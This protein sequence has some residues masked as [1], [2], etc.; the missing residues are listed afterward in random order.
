MRTRPL[1]TSF[2]SLALI[3]VLAACGADSVLPS[4]TPGSAGT[5]QPAATATAAG[6]PGDVAFAQMMIP[7][8]QQAIAMADMALT[9][10]STPQVGELAA[11]IKAAQDP[12]IA[13]MRSWLT[14]WGAPIAMPGTM[15]GMD[16]GTAGGSG[17]M[18][19]GEM[20]ALAAARGP[21][22]DTLWLQLMIRHHQ[23]AVQMATAVLGSTTNDE[24]RSL[25]DA[26]IAGQDTEIQIMQSLLTVTS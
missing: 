15:P 9:D 16:H 11:Q 4:G 14:G 12:E 13:R 7:H 8:H 21:A 23:G 18:D 19:E 5:D 17:M 2:G 24:V 3:A 25:A 22:F 1:L 10:A 26:I 20:S 6:A